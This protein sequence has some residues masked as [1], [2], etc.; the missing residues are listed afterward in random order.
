MD[1]PRYYFYVTFHS[2]KNVFR[3]N[4]DGSPAKPHKANKVLDSSEGLHGLRGMF[5]H[6][7]NL[8]LANSYKHDSK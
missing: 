2:K 3:Y 1:V 8:Y 7:G 6:N 5:V 4:L